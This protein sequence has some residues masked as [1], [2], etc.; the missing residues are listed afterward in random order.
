MNQ[1]G[2]RR[3]AMAQAIER[4]LNFGAMCE[5]NSLLLKFL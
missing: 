5:S 2:P 1:P 4:F 3:E